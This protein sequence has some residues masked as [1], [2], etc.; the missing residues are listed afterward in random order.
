MRGVESVKKGLEKTNL[1]VVP[2]LNKP[3]KK[4]SSL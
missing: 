4:S 2:K 3:I 1:Q